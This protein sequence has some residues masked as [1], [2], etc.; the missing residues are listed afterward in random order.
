L[1]GIWET[2]GRTARTT[3]KNG[4]RVETTQMESPIFYLFTF[5]VVF[6]FL[7]VCVLLFFGLFWPFVVLIGFRLSES[8][9]ST[10]YRPRQNLT[11]DTARPVATT[12]QSSGS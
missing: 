5:L 7:F 9:Y 8:V 3:T 4:N 10:R 11:Y 2:S 12:F 1:G 6:L